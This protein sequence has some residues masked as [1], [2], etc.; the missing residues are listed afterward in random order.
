GIEAIEKINTV[1]PEL[2]FLDIQLQDMDGFEIL[3]KTDHKP[4]VI[5]TT[6]YDQYAIKAFD[7]FAIDYLLKPIREERFKQSI[8]KLEL[9][10]DQNSNY[11][12][13]TLEK[14]I[15]SLQPKKTA[16]A[17][18]VKM[19]ERIILLSYD[20]ITYFEA[21]DKYVR[22]FVTDGTN[23]LTDLPLNKLIETLPAQFLRIQKSYIL[24]KLKIKE[25][26]KYFNGRY[27]F[28]LQ[29]KKGTQ[30]KSGLTYYDTIKAE[31]GI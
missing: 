30:L 27:I 23:Y 15:Q 24:N 3:K 5:F 4:L 1:K 20:N 19:G 29:D 21:D 9:L 22:V 26:N 13:E 14:L 10:T 31:F 11:T 18:P 25:L 8:T 6:A 28:T 16:T 7:E 12:N 17:F 2:L